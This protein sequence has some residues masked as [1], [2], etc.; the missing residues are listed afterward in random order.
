MPCIFHWILVFQVTIRAILLK[1]EVLCFTPTFSPCIDKLL[2]SVFYFTGMIMLQWWSLRV[3]IVFPTTIEKPSSRCA[4]NRKPWL[5][6]IK[7][8]LPG[9][10]HVL[11]S[12]HT[13]FSCALVTSCITPF[14]DLNSNNCIANDML[15]VFVGCLLTN[16]IYLIK[17]SLLMFCN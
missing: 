11:S 17:G 9:C 1:L 4:F 6:I 2:R 7:V 13:S 14:S 15:W 12:L 5:S 3:S 8:V 10:C 16:W